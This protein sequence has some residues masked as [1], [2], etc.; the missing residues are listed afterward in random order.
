MPNTHIETRKSRDKERVLS[1]TQ[2]LVRIPSV[3]R[4]GVEGGNEEKAALYVAAYLKK[5]GIEVHVEE[6]EPGRPNVIGV[7]DSGKPGRMLL[8]EGHTDVVTKGTVTRG[9]MILSVLK[10]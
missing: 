8:F 5:L 6:V 2:D 1:L 9:N 3:Y 4:P 7:V 10:L